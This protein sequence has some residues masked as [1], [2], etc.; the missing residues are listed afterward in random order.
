MTESEALDAHAHAQQLQESGQHEDAVSLLSGVAAWFAETEGEQSPDLANILADQAESL[1]ALCRYREA[2]QV[3]G[4]AQEIA[5]GVSK[6]LDPESRAILLP[7][8]LSVHASALRELGQYEEAA[9]SLHRAIAEAESYFGRDHVEVA[10][11]LNQFGV[12]CKYWGR[13]DEGEAAYRRAL[14]LLEAEFGVESPET[15]TIYHNLGGLEHS[16]G[17]FAEGEP[18]ARKAFD[19]RLEAFGPQDGR[20]IADEVEW[21]GLLDGLRRHSESIP[22]YER[23]LRFYEEHL[24][25]DHF[26][27]AAPL[28]NLGLARA[29]SGQA[30]SARASLERSLAIKRKLFHDDSHPEIRLAL[31]NLDQASPSGELT[32]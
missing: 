9:V 26:E 27:V 8:V 24:G 18:L 29:V 12:L 32:G 25:P 17:R 23:A 30:E 11:H 21:A 19:I 4:R 14:S 31:A 6:D 5:C 22:I 3:S 20:T 2:A 10:G 13:F 16:R 28:N 7:R 15:A 1:L